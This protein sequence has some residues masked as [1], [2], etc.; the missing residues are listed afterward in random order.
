M[1]KHEHRHQLSSYRFEP[2]RNE[3][4]QKEAAR[5]A[6]TKLS[7]R[8]LKRSSRAAVEITKLKHTHA[9]RETR[10][11]SPRLWREEGGGGR[12]PASSCWQSAPQRACVCAGAAGRSM[13]PPCS[14]LRL[15]AR[16]GCERLVVRACRR[17]RAHRKAH[18]QTPNSISALASLCVSLS[19][20]FWS[21]SQPS[22]AWTSAP[23]RCRERPSCTFLHRALDVALASQSSYH[24]SPCHPAPHPPASHRS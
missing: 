2:R 12:G 13:P 8:H 6:R 1:P 23:P 14:P 21:P 10:N 3:G 16:V 5:V 11:S 17:V 9:L 24:P 7:E 22:P 20:C 4:S 19:L 18:T 15:L